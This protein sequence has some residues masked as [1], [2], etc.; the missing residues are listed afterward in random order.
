MK[1]I[2]LCSDYEEKLFPYDKEW[3]PACLEVLNVSNIIHQVDFFIKNGI[4]PKDI[5]VF[6]GHQPK[7]VTHLLWKYSGI[8]LHGNF[9]DFRSFLAG[10]YPSL[11]EKTVIVKSDY[12]FVNEDLKKILHHHAEDSV[13]LTEKKESTEAICANVENDAIQYFLGHPRDH[14][15][16]HQVAGVYGLS[17]AAL[18]YII[19]SS[20]GFEKRISGSMIPDSFFIENGL[21]QYLDDGSQIKCKLADNKIFQ[22]RFPWDILNANVYHL[23]LLV[24]QLT[25]NDISPSAKIDKTASIHGVIKIGDHSYVG[26]NV[27]VNGNLIVGDH[28][29]IDNGAILN[30]N[31]LIGDHSYV[32]DYAKVEGSTVIGKENKFGHNAEFKGVSMKGVSAVHYSEM[33]G[34]MGR[35]VDVAAAC[36]AGI[37]RFNDTKQ[38]HNMTGRT[39]TPEHSNAIFIGDYTRTGINNVFFPGVKIGSNSAL[40]PGLN[41]EKDVA[42][43]TLVIKKQETIENR[44]G[45]KRYGW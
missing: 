25:E 5:H 34:I 12:V 39:Y 15:V 32:K 45:A 4:N 21:N 22:L 40:Y 31:I 35:Y 29:V 27:V 38:P 28:V 6:L 1:V 11:D 18:Q 7:Q 41:I 37:L 20:D 8:Q 3:Q 13:L 10:I 16:T 44:W 42:H 23:D 2:L 14:Y 26:K 36:V 17:K 24:K 9:N 43:E 30:G 19:H 33:F